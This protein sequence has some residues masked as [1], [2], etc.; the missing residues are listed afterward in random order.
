VA[1]ALPNSSGDLA[2]DRRLAMA[3]A[4]LSDGDTAAAIDLARQAL[5]RAPAWPAGWFRLGEMLERAGDPAAAEAFAAARRLDPEDPLGAGARLA[6][7]GAAPAEG[8]M[9]PR[10][11][12]E[13]FDQ[14]ADR[15]DDHL[16]NALSYQGPAIIKQAIAQCCAKLGRPFRFRAALDIGCGTGL[17][18]RAIASHV[19][20]MHGV[21]LS[22]R[23]VRKAME[24]G[25][26]ERDGLHV[27]DAVGHLEAV[28]AGSFD[29]LLAA[30][31]L[32]YMSD[33]NQIVRFSAQTLGIKG[34]FAFTFQLKNGDGFVLG[35]DLRYHHG[36][37]HARACAAAAG[38]AVAHAERCVPRRDAGGPVEGMVMVL[39]KPASD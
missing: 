30:D 19:D 6:R 1:A 8:A 37:A 17:M 3:E 7:I 25:L 12:A 22:P 14:Y 36:E 10:F 21:D 32:V 11:V 16:V 28:A 39:A 9:S 38:L 24:T 2:A 29:L 27:G 26:Y 33:L 5:E 13:L 18:A 34:L 35:D 15:F 4:Y 20:A 31:V 23:M